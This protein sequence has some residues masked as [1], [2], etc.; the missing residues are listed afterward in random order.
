MSGRTRCKSD[1]G[2]LVGEV[3]L[4]PRVLQRQ[5]VQS[6]R[7]EIEQGAK[8]ESKALAGVTLQPC[9]LQRLCR[10]QNDRLQRKRKT[11]NYT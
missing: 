9:M 5:Q 7:K 6:V 11:Y 1:C 4:Q 2:A 3:T 8:K 10:C